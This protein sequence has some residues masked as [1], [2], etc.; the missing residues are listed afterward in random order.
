MIADGLELTASVRARA[1]CGRYAP[2]PTGDLHLGNLRTALLAWL[3]AR[4]TG[5]LFVLRM[6]DLDLPRNRPGSAEAIVRDLRAL[7]LDWDEGCDLGGP[8]GPY[9][10]SRRNAFYTAALEMLQSS[11]RV[12]PC[13]CSRRDIR[14][15]AS[16]PH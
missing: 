12:F 3:Q 4:L 10:Q 11:G 2:S 15:A 6:E 1:P 5:G 8:L 7:G 14:E 16:A 9:T 13:Y